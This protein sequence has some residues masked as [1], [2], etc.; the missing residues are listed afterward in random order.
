[1]SSASGQGAELKQKGEQKAILQT[2]REGKHKNMAN[3]IER[4]G[5]G[6]R[7]E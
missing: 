6:D 4:I 7:L 2:T 1:M 5:Q 3:Q